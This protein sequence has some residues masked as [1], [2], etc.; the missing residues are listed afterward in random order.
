MFE[1]KIIFLVSESDLVFES[2]VK[3]MVCFESQEIME[4]LVKSAVCT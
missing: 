2:I 1:M 3:F 4:M